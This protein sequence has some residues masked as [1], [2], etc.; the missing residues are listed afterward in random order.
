VKN[1]F[2]KNKKIK[3]VDIETIVK[4]EQLKN[5]VLLTLLKRGE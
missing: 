5:S 2:K 3:P 1:L 4:F